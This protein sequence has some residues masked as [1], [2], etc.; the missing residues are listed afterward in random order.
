M[1]DDPEDQ[2]KDAELSR[3]LREGADPQP[4][5]GL[6]AR[7]ARSYQRTAVPSWAARAWRARLSLPAP[8]AAL[9]LIALLTAGALARDLRWPRFAGPVPASSGLAG[10]KP[11]AEVQIR[12]ASKE[13]R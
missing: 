10:L 12:V 6:D 11:L 7:V 4:P 2:E 8:V 13:G 5:P 3:W 1:T 9:L